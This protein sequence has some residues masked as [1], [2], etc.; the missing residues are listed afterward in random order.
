MVDRLPAA[1]AND[2]MVLLQKANH[3]G[4]LTEAEEKVWAN[5][6]ETD[7]SAKKYRKTFRHAGQKMAIRHGQLQKQFMRWINAGTVQK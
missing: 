6:V 2:Y 3:K 7:M 1:S 5:I 4:G